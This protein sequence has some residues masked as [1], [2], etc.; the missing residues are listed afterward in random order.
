[1]NRGRS[2]S[3]PPSPPSGG[4]R[5]QLDRRAFARLM[6]AGAVGAFKPWGAGAAEP[7]RLLGYIRTNWSEDPF[8]FGSYSFVAKGARQRDR[9]RLED[10][11]DGRIFFAGE[12]V[13]P[14]YNSTVHAAYESGQRTAGFVLGEDRKRV[15]I[16]GAGISGLSAAH[17][18]SEHDVA[19]TVFEARD[20]I[21]GRIWT[22]DRLRIP[23]DLGASWIHGIDGNP[24]SKL[25]D[26]L[27]L[28]R[29]TTD[30]S[31]IV[32][33]KGGQKMDW[34]DVPEWL[35]NVVSYQHNA[36]ADYD[37]INTAAYLLQF[38]YEGDEVIF[39]DGFGSILDA[40]T[41]TYT[42]RLS[43]IVSEISLGDKGVSLLA[44]NGPEAF[45]AVIVTVPLGVLKQ[46]RIRFAPPLPRA[47]R[48][49]I[50]R[51][52]MGT[53]D[54]IYLLFEEPFWDTDA[55]WIVTPQNGL[56]P[57]QFNS[58]LNLYKYLQEPVIMAF[59]GGPP[60][61]Q[62]A[63]LSDEKVVRRAIDTLNGAYP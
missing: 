59:N 42:L 36:G 58:W 13:F 57:G 31:Y 12:A 52:G 10:P 24:I 6:V 41:G 32:R 4:G 61:L 21:G 34:D 1:M 39:P 22:S 11:I 37:R 18:L 17:R 48:A 33:G 46:D 26:S 35:D 63:K 8:S 53:L 44:G 45:D 30:D 62:I 9:R 19:V 40:L 2:V 14:S 23:L 49:A 56:P 25:A 55:T 15:A 43:S 3:E 5:A 54:K 47:K 50:K 29:V 27:H 16:V 7:E 38:D 60:A 51:L 20:R 28:A